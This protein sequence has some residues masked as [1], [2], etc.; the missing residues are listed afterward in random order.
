MGW[1]KTDIEANAPSFVAKASTGETG[2]DLYGTEVFGVSVE[3]ANAARADGKGSIQP[4]WV[5]KT[6]AGSRE[7]YETLVAI[8]RNGAKAAVFG[9]GTDDTELPDA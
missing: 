7:R 4:G 8:S 3:E 2:V 6:T 5:K 1:G 9:D